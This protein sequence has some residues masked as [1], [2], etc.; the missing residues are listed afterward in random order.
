MLLLSKFIGIFD[1]PPTIYKVIYG[2]Y[3]PIALD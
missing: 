2:K 1:Y 3:I